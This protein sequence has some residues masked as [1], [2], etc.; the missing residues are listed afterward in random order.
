MVDAKQRGDKAAAIEASRQMR[1]PVKR[2]QELR[3]AHYWEEL[4]LVRYHP[5]VNSV[6]VYCPKTNWQARALAL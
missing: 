2:E 1:D 4:A 3:A 5:A 6:A